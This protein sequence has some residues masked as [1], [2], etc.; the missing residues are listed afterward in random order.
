MK[1]LH[2]SLDFILKYLKKKNVGFE[3]KI[4]NY[5]KSV[6]IAIV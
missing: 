1:L 5:W 6:D 4:L 3:D 2:A